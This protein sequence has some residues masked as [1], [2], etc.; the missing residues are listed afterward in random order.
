[1]WNRLQDLPHLVNNLV[2]RG[3]LLG[4]YNDGKILRARVKTG[5]DIENDRLDVI[6]PV[7]FSAHVAPGPGTEVLTLDVGADPSRR[8]VLSIFGDR[9]THPQPD[10]GEVYFYAPGDPTR[11][12]RIK[13][14]GDSQSRS[15]TARDSGRETGLEI[16]MGDLPVVI[17]TDKTVLIESPEG[18]TIKAETVRIEGDLRVTGEVTAR[19]DG[20]A[21]H[22]STH[23]HG[24]VESGGST[25]DPPIAG[26]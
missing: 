25:T 3:Y 9:A 24:G 16:S 23:R 21:V 8:V 4:T 11:Y 13:R 2:R 15:V 20:G 14:A 12:I 17:R 7:G 10:E 1:M 19:I 5:V 18:V 22:L 26:S 6:Q